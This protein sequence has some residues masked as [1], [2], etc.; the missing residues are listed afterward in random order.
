[1]FPLVRRTVDTEVTAA[2]VLVSAAP[3][4]ETGD[5]EDNATERTFLGNDFVSRLFL[6]LLLY[7]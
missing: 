4:I 2:C 7:A 6:G 1:L 5:I 3:R